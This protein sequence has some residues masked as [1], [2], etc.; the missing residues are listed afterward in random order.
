MAKKKESGPVSLN[1]QLD[2]ELSEA[3]ATDYIK[4]AENC[5][6]MDL[7]CVPTGFPQ[8]DVILHPTLR[9]FPLG[10]DMEI[11][12]R[13][14][15]LGKTSIAL[16]FL[17]AAQRAGLRTLYDDV[18]RT[19]TLQYLKDMGLQIDPEENTARYAVRLM[20]HEKE[21]IPAE[22]WLD[23]IRK[24][25]NLMHVIAVDSVA[26]LDKKANL[27][28]SS[29]DPNQIGGVSLML[30]EFYKKN[31][32]KQ[33]TILWINQM[34][35]KVGA[36]SPQGGEV[37]DTPGGRAIKFYT[38]IRLELSFVDKIKES[39]DGDPVGMKIRVFTAKNKI[40]PQWRQCNLSYLFGYGFSPLW[41]YM[42]L[43]QKMGVVEKKGSWMNF[44]DKKAQGP[45]N[46]HRMM[47]EDK[48]LSDQIKL[49]VDG[50][51]AVAGANSSQGE[52]PD[53]A[54]E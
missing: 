11:F 54:E 15:E 38:S 48:E 4:L 12:S 16:E 36:Y 46:F 17:K 35:S 50:E 49:M 5:C 39:K 8:L 37:L 14:P 42:E 28:K 25:A 21:A 53:G 47:A 19:M 10:R 18:E 3:G 34:R 9:G 31:V 6:D 23:T 45:L 29:S 41:D 2:K 44:G 1:A 33:A 7:V 22:I 30:S 51:D 26:A 32:V 13:Q 24:V 43:A 52:K 40:A 27:E 20:R